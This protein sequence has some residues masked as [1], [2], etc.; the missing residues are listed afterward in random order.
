MTCVLLLDTQPRTHNFYI[1]LSIADALRRHPRVTRLILASHGN[2]VRL[3][4]E[5]DID[6][7]I[8]FGGSETHPAL[9]ARLCRLSRLS[10]LWTTEDPYQLAGNVRTSTCFDLVF[11]NDKASVPAYSGRAHHLPL[12]ASQLFQDF[13]VSHQ[14]DHYFYDVLFIG[15]AWPNRVDTLNRLLSEFDGTIKAKIALPWNEYIGPPDLNVPG[16]IT[17][18]R[19]GNADFARFANR[20]RIVLTLPRYFSAASDAQTTGSSPPP[21]LFEAGLAGGFQV[22][23]S[24]EI[25]TGDYYVSGHEIV[26]Y[27]GDDS[28]LATVRDVL[29]QPVKRREM[30]LAAKTRTL[31]EHLY[32]HRVDRLLGVA[33]PGKAAIR[34]ARKVVMFVAHNRI[35]HEPG[36]GVE[37]YQEVLAKNLEHYEAVFFFPMR[38]EGRF[39]VCAQGR[40]FSRELEIKGWNSLVLY[41]SAIEGFFER[42]AIEYKVD[43]IHFHHLLYLPLSLPL[44]ARALGIP[45]VWQMHDY[46]LICDRYQLLTFDQ[47][48]C[49]VVHRGSGQCDGCLLG[50]D[51]RPPGSKARRD[52]L[53]AIIARSIDAFVASTAF[54]ANYLRQFFSEIPAGCVHIVEL[55]YTVG[56]VPVRE[57]RTSTGTLHVAVP[58]NLT[59]GKGG[60]Y[61]VELFRRCQQYDMTFHILG[62]VVDGLLDSLS[63]VDSRKLQLRG[64][65]E[66]KELPALL[67]SCDVSL[68]L[69]VWPETFIFSLT[70]AWQAGLVPIVTDLGAPSDRVTHGVDGI[71]VQPNDP[72]AVFEHLE[73][74]YFDREIIERMRAEIARKTFVSPEANA[75]EIEIIYDRLASQ[76]PCPHTDIP[77][78]LRSFDLTLF[79]AGVRVNSPSWATSDNL[80]DAN[81]GPTLQSPPKFGAAV[82]TELS[83]GELALPLTTVNLSGGTARINLERFEVDRCEVSSTD[84]HVAFE[85]LAVAGWMVVK[86][87][88]HDAV[89]TYL[90]LKNLDGIRYARLSSIR[91]D[92]VAQVLGRAELQHAGFSGAL[93]I[94]A[95]PNG[96]YAVDVM[97]FTESAGFVIEDMF[98][99]AAQSATSFGQAYAP[100]PRR[101]VADAYLRGK[102]SQV[103]T[104]AIEVTSHNL[105]QIAG[106][107]VGSVNDTAW[108]E[109]RGLAQMSGPAAVI[110]IL[111]RA[112]SDVAYEAP[113]CVS[114]PA[115]SGN[116][117]IVC[118][119]E[120]LPIG[121]YSLMIAHIGLNTVGLQSSGFELSISPDRRFG[122]TSSAPI[123]A[124]AKRV[125]RVG[126]KPSRLELDQIEVLSLVEGDSGRKVLNGEGWAFIG[127]YGAPRFAVVAWTGG[128]GDLRYCMCSP[129]SRPDARTAIGRDEAE[130]T[131]F[132]FSLPLDALDRRG[133]RLFQEY[134]NDTFEFKNF[135]ACVRDQYGKIR[136]AA[137]NAAESAREE[138]EGG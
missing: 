51:D 13:P 36:G 99:F 47:R 71:K 134:Q 68:H 63:L 76:H 30:A 43:I 131:G 40:E 122:W 69:S 75:S 130:H 14:E 98:D 74:L 113:V 93:A 121:N 49:D 82:L 27:E 92:D 66:V 72:A 12:A 116:F 41:D 22:I 88:K 119:L 135:E 70:E 89:R 55:P 18:W 120:G 11:T 23:A 3:A 20:S 7:F 125:P 80:W 48:F 124:N 61:L 33:V 90:R 16:L 45:A 19:C 50:L 83:E 8:A 78:L 73:S 123:R 54:S 44:I 59:I 5:S 115:S 6:V 127:G 56:S 103:I 60:R 96:T 64:G 105:Q 137:G 84:K 53:T 129:I 94:D 81:Y 132:A 101:Y 97:Q 28:I 109:A 42:V 1:T 67:A 38:R 102:P 21:R 15:T 136:S 128:D 39:F 112:D 107:A 65:Y 29:A 87:S 85:E 34:S 95:L 110:A 32:S 2:A 100:K 24:S 26:V 58:G 17:D 25:E 111:R 62:R 117:T 133:I 31:R 118:K 79:D 91:R 106:L 104:S 4:Q 86:E 35:G 37:I 52:N 46:Y 114:R 126:W 57:E 108:I 138:A 9:L 10:V 77:N